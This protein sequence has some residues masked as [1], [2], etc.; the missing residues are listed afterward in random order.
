MCWL[1]RAQS[2]GGMMISRGKLKK[3]REIYNGAISCYESHM[4]SPGTDTETL[5]SEANR[6][7]LQL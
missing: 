2:N 3:L 4:M 6:K 7:P 5:W 1:V